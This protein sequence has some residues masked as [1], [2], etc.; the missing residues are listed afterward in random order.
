MILTV[1]MIN[2]LKINSKLF[3]PEVC[4]SCLVWYIDLV[5]IYENLIVISV[6]KWRW[7]ID[8]NLQ[9]IG[10][11]SNLTWAYKKKER[12]SHQT[13]NLLLSYQKHT[14]KSF[15][16]HSQH[17]FHIRSF[18]SYIFFSPSVYFFQKQICKQGKQKQSKSKQKN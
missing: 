8:I 12:K 5:F 17:I 6:F 3:L 15:N 1:T 4:Q 18:H 9:F 16:Q 10:F 13:W 11:L 14:S 2:S 7:K